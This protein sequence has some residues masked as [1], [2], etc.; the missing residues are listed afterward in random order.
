VSGGCDRCPARD[1]RV[2]RVL[3]ERAFEMAL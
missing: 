3:P 2:R 1:E